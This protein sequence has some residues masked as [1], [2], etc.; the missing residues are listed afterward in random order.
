MKTVQPVLS[1][2]C[3]SL[4]SLSLWM[5]H[6][7]AT[8]STSPLEDSVVTDAPIEEASQELGGSAENSEDD[9]TTR[10]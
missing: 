2:F 6:A 4:L 10:R 9:G 7:C 5:L 3:L 1:L 8:D